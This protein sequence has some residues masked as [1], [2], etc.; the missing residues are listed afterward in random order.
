M[1]EAYST[2]IGDL[3][4][5]SRVISDKQK[6]LLIHVVNKQ[7]SFAGSGKPEDAGEVELVSFF[8]A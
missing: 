5:D 7:L 2:Q 4:N 8:Y 1:F 6:N 3:K